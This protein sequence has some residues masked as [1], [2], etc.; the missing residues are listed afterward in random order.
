MKKMT[1][2]F[3]SLTLMLALNLFGQG[4]GEFNSQKLD[5]ISLNSDLDSDEDGFEELEC[6]LR[7]IQRKSQSTCSEFHH[8]AIIEGVDS[9]SLNWCGYAAITGKSEMPNP[10]I[11]SVTQ[12]SGSW[13]VPTVEA[14]EN[15]NTFSSAWVGIDGFA[16]QVVEQI[17]T[18]HDV[19]DGQPSYFAWFSLFPA[20]TQEV[21]G[22]PVNPGDVIHARVA[23]KGQDD[24]GNSV[25]RLTIK[26]QTH[27]V[28]FST[29]QHT[30]PGNPAHLSSAEWIVEAPIV[31]DPRIPCINIGIL[32]LAKFDKISFDDCRTVID[33]IEGGIKNKHWTFDAI[34]MVSGTTTKAK[35]S[36]LCKGGLSSDPSKRKESSFEVKWVSPGPFPFQVYCPPI[37]P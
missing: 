31:V 30:L 8:G 24:C 12:V 13:V 11:N 3:L 18:E 21:E 15:G 14:N 23:F 5:F 19:I 37:V 29:F 16:S 17:G 33:G 28:K 6:S 34:T 22:F 7:P 20:A 27:K 25:F 36:V 35:P 26:N 4:A 9:K 2:T 1:L 10:T 32:P